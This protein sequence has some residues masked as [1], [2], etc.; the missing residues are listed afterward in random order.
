MFSFQVFPDRIGHKLQW[1]QSTEYI[2]YKTQRPLFWPEI[3]FWVLFFI[4]WQL[5]VRATLHYL[6]FQC[7]TTAQGGPNAVEVVVQS[8][9]SRFSL[10]P[11]SVIFLLSGQGFSRH[12]VLIL[13]SIVRLLLT[14]YRVQTTRLEM[15]RI[16]VSSLEIAHML[17][18]F[19]NPPLDAQAADYLP[20]II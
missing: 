4:G 16:R 1:P 12:V 20:L 9:I 6:G 7:A 10:L 18:K 3:I 14:L 19:S 2:N 11:A 13:V 15:A 8:M 17:I 5:G